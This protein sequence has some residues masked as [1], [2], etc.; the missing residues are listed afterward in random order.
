MKSRTMRCVGHVIR[1][2]RC[3]MHVIFQPEDLEKGDNIKQHAFIYVKH[4]GVV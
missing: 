4:P 1:I 2:E 3:E